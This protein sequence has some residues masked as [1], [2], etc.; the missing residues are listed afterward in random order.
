[1][2]KQK[3]KSSLESALE[4][5]LDIFK[6]VLTGEIHHGVSKRIHPFSFNNHRGKETVQED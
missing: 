3:K 6:S 5:K 4:S 1:M 2:V